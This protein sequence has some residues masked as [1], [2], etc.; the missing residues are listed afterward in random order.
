MVTLGKPTEGNPYRDELTE[1]GYLI[2]ESQ[3]RQSFRSPAVQKLLN[4]EPSK[5]N[6]HLFV[7]PSDDCAYTYF[8]LLEY[9]SHDP[10]PHRILFI[11]FGR[12]LDG[13]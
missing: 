12:F 8:G 2:W 6:I 4:H 3:T 13:T 5:A 9:F 7:R 1:D 10:R 11:L